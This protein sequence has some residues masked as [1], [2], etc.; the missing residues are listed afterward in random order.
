VP[1]NANQRLE[2]DQ[3]EKLKPILQDQHKQMKAVRD[4]TSLT[5]DQKH[6]K[7]KQIHESTP[8]TNSGNPDT[9]ATREI[10]ATE[11]RR[12]GATE[13]GSQGEGESKQPQ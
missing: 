4:D 12:D 11:R 9:G 2:D 13:R 6:E 1:K 5:Q 3:K 10:Q 7:M 8:H